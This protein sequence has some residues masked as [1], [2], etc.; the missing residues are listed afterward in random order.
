MRNVM[1]DQF[2]LRATYKPTGEVLEYGPFEHNEGDDPQKLTSTVLFAQGFVC[3]TLFERT[4]TEVTPETIEFSLVGVDY[5]PT[6]TA[7]LG[8]LQAE[9]TASVTHADGTT[10]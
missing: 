9:A 2:K 7:V 6:G 8:S 10:D 5:Q 1:A 3:G 4:Q